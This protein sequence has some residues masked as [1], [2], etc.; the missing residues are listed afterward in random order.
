MGGRDH[1][2]RGRTLVADVDIRVEDLARRR[3]GDNLY[4]E[5]H[6]PRQ[7]FIRRSILASE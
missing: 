2:R 7:E 3:L 1:R 5:S 6:V 4:F